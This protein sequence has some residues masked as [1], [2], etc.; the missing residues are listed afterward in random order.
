[1]PGS[2]AAA[3]WAPRSAIVNGTDAMDAPIEIR[4]GAD[5]IVITFTDHPTEL[6][7]LL[8]TPAGV[9]ASDYFIIIF[10]TD[11]AQWS[12]QSRRTVMARPTNLG[13]YAVRNLPPGEYYLAA[14]TDVI[15]NE[16]FDPA[17]LES[18][19]PAS[20]RVTLGES[21]RK[22]QDVRIAR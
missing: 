8:Q 5:G 3:G 21:E 11:R 17:F 19:V 13:R 15:Q 14:V 10:A 18:L 7:G 9:A 20:I 4:Q 6:S 22:M 1:V 12:A 2:T 16:W